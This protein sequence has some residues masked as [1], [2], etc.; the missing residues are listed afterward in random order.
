[1]VKA[2]FG[3]KNGS[4]KIIFSYCCVHELTEED[5]QVIYVGFQTAGEKDAYV[6]WS[7]EILK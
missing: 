6:R 3:E 7:N 4:N 2:H 1:M 5:H